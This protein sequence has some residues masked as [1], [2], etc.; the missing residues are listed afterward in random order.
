LTAIDERCAPGASSWDVLVWDSLLLHRVRRL[1][2]ERI[3]LLVHYLPSLEP[4][5]D[6]AL[7]AVRYAEEDRAAA[8]AE[9]CIVTGRELADCIRVRWPSMRVFVCEPGVGA[10]FQ[11]RSLRKAET[12]VRLLTVANL[13][14]AKGHEAAFEVLQRLRDRPWRWDLVGEAVVDGGVAERLRARAE[15]TG[16]SDRIAWHGTL[17]P[18]QVA[19][20]MARADVLLQ[21]SRFESYGMALAE[22]V[23]VGLPAV[24]FRVGA[25]E[26]LVRHGETGFLAAPGDWEALGEALRALLQAR[27]RTRLE[28]NLAAGPVRGWD[29][30]C[31]EFRAACEAMLR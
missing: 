16:L 29:A 5:I 21:P 20:M 25:A 17:V 10:A 26:R 27:V 4:Q 13:L 22:A 28:R 2:R 11:R 30:T 15:E 9:F 12:T 23:A 8:L 1:A 3:G 7:A 18:T 24:A 6:P 19:A 14:P 31:A